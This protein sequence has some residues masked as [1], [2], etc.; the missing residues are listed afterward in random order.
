MSLRNTTVLL[1]TS[2]LQL[3]R[4]NKTCSKELVIGELGAEKTCYSSL[5]FC[6]PQS[7]E[8]SASG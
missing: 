7:T 3:H 4:A 5:N 6:D 2:E 8:S 1:Y